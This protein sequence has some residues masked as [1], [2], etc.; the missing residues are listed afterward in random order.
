MKLLSSL[1]FA[2]L[3]LLFSACFLNL[4][5]LISFLDFLFMSSQSSVSSSL[6]FQFNRFLLPE[7][8]IQYLHVFHLRA[9]LPED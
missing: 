8:H 3:A 1:A 5:L 7:K 4:A 9:W 6:I 2:C